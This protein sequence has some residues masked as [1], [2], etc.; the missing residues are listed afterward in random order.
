MQDA[1]DFHREH[2]SPA[3]AIAAIVGDIDIET[4]RA[5]LD[6]TFGEIPARPA[7]PRPQAAEPPR[8]SERRSTVFVEAA[9][10]LAMAFL[11]PTLPTRED[12]IF[13]VIELL[14][15]DGRASRLYRALV[16]K[17]GLC[18]DVVGTM[19]PGARLPHLYALLATPLAGKPAAAVE[20]ALLREIE[21]LKDEP[22]SEAELV[23]VRTKL[24]ADFSR[25]I[26]TNA[27]LAESLSFF[28]AI[29]G[30][31]RYLAD[32]RQQI[33]SITAED[34]RRVAREYLVAENRTVVVLQRPEKA[35]EAP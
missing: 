31:W 11:K 8:H 29:A 32:H 35:P 13:D 15:T 17:E 22:V 12:Y 24:D 7:P 3:N 14:M 10:Q 33:A 18:S 16:T 5:L 25:Q 26:A 21:R 23:R 20:A 27:G 9:P 2:Y 4:T 6:R 1:L 34:V 30:D 28:E 19:T